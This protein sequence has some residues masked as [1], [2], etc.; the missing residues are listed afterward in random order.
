M[1][2]RIKDL[3]IY[4]DV[5]IFKPLY[6]LWIRII[7]KRVVRCKDCLRMKRFNECYFTYGIYYFWLNM[8]EKNRFNSC[9]RFIGEEDI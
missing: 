5:N 4:L 8:E 9:E 7:G 3:K 6:Y 2:E 1:K